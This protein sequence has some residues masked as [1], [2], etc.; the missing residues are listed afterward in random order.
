[1]GLYVNTNVA[2]LNAQRN[3][4][5]SQSDLAKSFARLSSGLRIN[6]AADDAAGLAIAERFTSQIRG[7]SQAVRNAND[8]ISLAQVAEGA[9]QQIMANL[10]RV[11]ELAVQAA[12][13]VNTESDRQSLQEEIEQLKDELTRIGNTTTF[14]G[15]KLLDGTF[16]NKYFH[17]GM[18]FREALEISVPD[19]RSD[20]LGRQAVLTGAVVATGA[21][22]GGDVLI[23]GIT[24]RGTQ[25]A[26]DTV[27]T[28]FATGSAI[29]KAEA[30]ND[31]T[32][33]TGV[34]AYANRTVLLG[35][36]AIGGGT[37]DDVNNIQI[38][39]EIITG[40]SVSADDAN[41]NLI[42]AINAVTDRTGVVAFRTDDGNLKLEAEDG[43]NIELVV[44]GA[45]GA[46]TGFTT[47]QVQTADLTLF[48]E[49]QYLVSGNDEGLIGFANDERVG[50]NSVQAVDTMDVTSRDGANLAILIVDRALGQISSKR[51]EMGAIMNRM[52]AT[53]TNLTTVVENSSA[54][55]SRILDADFAAETARLSR[56]QVLTQAANTILAQA[57]QQPQQVLSLLQGG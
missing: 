36:A 39:G 24:I 44:R 49:E 22:T 38:N 55:R 52:S 18:N 7:L 8:A 46:R 32:E 20:V 56:N 5:H 41:E 29:A 33:F 17:I 15:K 26:D 9:M 19:A 14:N 27:S 11:R 25:S 16:I 28:S 34:G 23:N 45:G 4:L 12:N 53:I 51:S 6:T 2:S 54:A 13:D 30:I 43:R 48:S 1:M 21:I 35:D 3:L 37:L 10:Q 57:N 50:V 40:V 42:R 47:T 31:S